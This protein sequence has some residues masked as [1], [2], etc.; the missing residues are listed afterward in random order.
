M[1]TMHVLQNFTTNPV[2]F[3][4]PLIVIFTQSEASIK[5]I[6]M[7]TAFYHLEILASFL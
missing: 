2:G 7:T 4:V 3:H 6:F 1:D 5:R